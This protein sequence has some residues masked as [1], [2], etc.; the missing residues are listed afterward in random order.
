MPFDV[1]STDALKQSSLEADALGH[2]F[3]G[4]EHVLLG[5]CAADGSGVERALGIAPSRIR[6]EVLRLLSGDPE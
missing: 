5:L 3:V 1:A 2:G 6:H 4:T